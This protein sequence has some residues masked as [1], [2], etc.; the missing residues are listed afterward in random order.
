MNKILP[1]LCVFIAFST[2]TFAQVFSGGTT[3]GIPDNNC[4]AT[5]E[6]T[7][8]VSGL[9]ASI[10]GSFGLE[11]VCLDIS[12]T[13]NSDL[14]VF[15]IAPDGTEAEL[16]TDVG[17]STDNFTGT[18]LNMAG[19]DG[20]ISSGSGP[21]TGS[22]I[23]E[24]DLGVINNGQDP[25]GTWTLRVCDDVGDDTGDLNSWSI[26]FSNDPAQPP[27]PPPANDLCSGALDVEAAQM[28]MG[29]TGGSAT[30]TDAPPFCV[31]SLNTAPGLW[32]KYTSTVSETVTLDLCTASFDTKIGV[33]TT[34][35]CITFNCINGNDDDTGTGGASACGGGTVS[36]TSFTTTA[37]S[38]ARLAPEVYY[39]Y[40]TGFSTNTGTFT[41]NVAAAALPV[42]LLAFDVEAMDKA[43]KVS[44]STA[45]EENTEYFAIERSA[46]GTNN[47]VEISQ[48]KANGF[49][50]TKI[51]Y[52]FI[53]EAPISTSYYRLRSVDFDGKNQLS[54]VVVV[55][56]NDNQFGVIGIRPVPTT[57]V[58][59]IEFETTR[60]EIV[61][62]RIMDISGKLLFTNS[63]EANDGY[64]SR[65]LDLTQYA[66]GVYF[67][68]LENSVQKITHRVM[69][70]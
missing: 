43:N 26:E 7:V 13:W 55:E 54:E 48:V 11:E 4:D 10:D 46:D 60:N 3:G 29:D 64:N 8:A 23:P 6:F 9:A 53:D 18:C 21:F 28:Y 50:Q 70:N 65:L 36:S 17:S 52:E 16:F 2:T 27:A 61:T 1:M 41:L 14:D 24:G 69:K 44:W 47:W 12:H 66:N 22:Y 33:F 32:Y 19:A 45:S 39:I 31:T 5:N 40:V 25:N 30:S 42:E 34:D 35:D 38:G 57:D 63:F 51:D 58:T 37:S 56:R 68:S 49:S 59:T 62:L 15:L 67:V 20:A